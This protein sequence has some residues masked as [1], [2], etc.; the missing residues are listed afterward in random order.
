M[1]HGA[2]RS[3]KTESGS[4]AGPTRI[5]AKAKPLAAALA[6]ASKLAIA[7]HAAAALKPEPSAEEVRQWIATAAYYHAQ[8]RNFEAGDALQDW[9]KAEQEI[10]HLLAA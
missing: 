5:A 7:E 2:T 9:L 4:A 1:K 8:K 3:T 6:D 10:S